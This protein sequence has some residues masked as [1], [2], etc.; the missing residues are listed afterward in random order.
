VVYYYNELRGMEIPVFEVM[1]IV[2]LILVFGWLYVTRMEFLRSQPFVCRWFP[3]LALHKEMP[4]ITEESIVRAINLNPFDLPM[5]NVLFNNWPKFTKKRLARTKMLVLCASNFSA[6]H[7]IKDVSFAFQTMVGI[8]G[9][10]PELD[11]GMS[12][13]FFD[14]NVILS[15]EVIPTLTSCPNIT[16]LCLCLEQPLNFSWDREKDFFTNF[17]NG[18]QRLNLQHF[19]KV[20]VIIANH[21]EL[22]SPKQ[23]PVQIARG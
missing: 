15:D 14:A 18:F 2:V 9:I 3:F 13:F 1:I 22:Q 5:N 6:R 17:A 21:G 12:V 4:E 10:K 23:F 8:F 11:D 19:K 16:T 7:T 20:F